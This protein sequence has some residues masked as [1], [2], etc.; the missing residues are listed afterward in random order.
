MGD[1]WTVMWKEKKLL[2][3]P[4]GSR[5]RALFVLLVPVLMLAIYLPWQEG[6][7]WVESPFTFITGV[8]I[9]M[10]LVGTVIPES[11]AGERERHTLGTLLASRLSD[12]TILFGKMGTAVGYGWGMTILTLLLSL[13]T[14][15]VTHWNGVI[16]FF[17]PTIL[18]ANLV[19]SLLLAIIMAG[20]GI[21]ISLRS[22]TVQGATQALMAI[23]MFPLIVLQIA[24]ILVLQMQRDLLDNV[25]ETLRS[26]DSGQ[27][28]L[29]VSAVLILACLVLM[30]IVIKRFQR[31]RLILN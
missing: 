16:A 6:Q 13:V 24:G 23:T 26:A 3:R 7:R 30:R 29:I 21:L 1:I 18:L 2:L 5:F 17:T 31:A 9:P 15:N 11:F 22:A 4:Q 20:F 10:L 8:L 28:I 27:L 19:I 14:V 12:R 25:I